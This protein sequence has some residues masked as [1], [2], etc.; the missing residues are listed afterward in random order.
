MANTTQLA[1]LGPEDAIFDQEEIRDH[2]TNSPTNV[3][4]DSSE[5]VIEK[6]ILVDPEEA[7][8]VQGEASS[9]AALGDSN[10]ANPSMT[11]EK[12]N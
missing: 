7:D 10:L 11:G 1:T 6:A 2:Q 3:D 9:D 12:T 8:K 4:I 5:P